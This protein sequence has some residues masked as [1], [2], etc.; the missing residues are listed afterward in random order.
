MGKVHVCILSFEKHNPKRTDQKRFT[1]FRTEN[2]FAQSESLYGVSLEHMAIFFMLV[3]LAQERDTDTIEFESGWFCSVW[4]GGKLK[5]EQ[6]LSALGALNGKVLTA[7]GLEPDPVQT[8]NGDVPGTARY[9]R[10]NDTNEHAPRKRPQTEWP[11]EVEAAYARFPR[12]KGKTAGMKVLMRDRC[13][14][15]TRTCSSR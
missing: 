8:C 9:E 12:K 7:T 14:R 10:T 11:P 6:L 2:R 13:L 15:T 5:E 3:G 1:W 4:T